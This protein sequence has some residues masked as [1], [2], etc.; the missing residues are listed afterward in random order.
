MPFDLERFAHELGET[1][2][3]LVRPHY[4]STVVVPP[5]LRGTVRNV[6]DV[7]DVTSLL[8][9]TDTLITDYSSIMFDYALLDRP[10]VFFA[11]DLEEYVRCRGAYFD[12]AEHAPGPDWDGVWTLTER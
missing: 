3:L 12:L 1:H 2:V 9:L 4:L 6:A 10:M 5:S 11:S 7:D 8:L